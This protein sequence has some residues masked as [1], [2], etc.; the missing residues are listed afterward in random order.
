M[1]ARCLQ[2]SYEPSAELRVR[3]ILTEY[4]LPIDGRASV[5]AEMT[6]PDGTAATL[7]MAEIEPGV[8][9]AL[10][11]A[12]Q[13]GVY[14]FYVVAKGHTLRDYAFTREQIVTGFTYHGGDTPSAHDPRATENCCNVLQCLVGAL[15]PQFCDRMGIDLDR[16]RRCLSEHCADPH[17]AAT[18]TPADIDPADI[19]LIRDVATRLGLIGARARRRDQPDY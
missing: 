14:H 1:T 11:V 19:D 4:G 16:L 13:S 3:A 5:R 17:G 15:S 8:F 18:T 2:D 10:E 6:R 9:E 12:H 7:S